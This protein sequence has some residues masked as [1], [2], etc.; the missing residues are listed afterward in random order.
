MLPNSK[1][2]TIQRDDLLSPLTV[3][4]VIAKEIIKF[5]VANGGASPQDSYTLGS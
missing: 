4:M 2:Y 5:G 3:V 1:T